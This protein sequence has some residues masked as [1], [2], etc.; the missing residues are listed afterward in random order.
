MREPLNALFP[1]ELRHSPEL[2]DV[3]C[4]C[5]EQLSLRYNPSRC[6]G[7]DREAGKA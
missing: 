3:I 7:E 1:A 5:Y 6:S 2:A 4:H